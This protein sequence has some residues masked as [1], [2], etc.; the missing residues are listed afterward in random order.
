MKT[1][2][3]LS[4]IPPFLGVAVFLFGIYQYRIQQKAAREQQEVAS[5]R[6]I[7]QRQLEVIK[8][9]LTKRTELYLEASASAAR[10]AVSTDTEERLKAEAKFWELYVGQMVIVEDSEVANA[11]VDFGASL[12]KTERDKLEIWNRSLFLATSMRNSI[13]KSFQLDL[14]D[15]NINNR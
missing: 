8:P 15:L 2:E 4:I 3:I 14:Q 5:D 12:K 7:E 6:N 13:S 9:F 11:M 10:I 1:N